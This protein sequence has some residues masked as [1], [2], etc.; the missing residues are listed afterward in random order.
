M[1]VSLAAE[2]AHVD[3]EFVALIVAPLAVV[4][5]AGARDVAQLALAVALA[6][7]PLADVL[8]AVLVG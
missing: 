3:A 8:A 5:G 2:A 4:A 6:V 7:L 1:G